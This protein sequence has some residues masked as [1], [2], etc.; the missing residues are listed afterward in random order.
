MKKEVL[1]N[2]PYNVSLAAICMYFTFSLGEL[3]SFFGKMIKHECKRQRTRTTAWKTE[4]PRNLRSRRS[5]RK[6]TSEMDSPSYF[7][8]ERVRD[9]EKE[10]EIERN[11]KREWQRPKYRDTPFKRNGDKSKGNTTEWNENEKGNEWKRKRERERNT[12]ENGAKIMR[13]RKN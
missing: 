1:N 8:L 5:R 9:G 2:N 6:S 7:I 4:K 3:I 11:R 10:K 13:E 12:N